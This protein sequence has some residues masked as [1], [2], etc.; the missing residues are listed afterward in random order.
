MCGNSSKFIM[1]IAAI[2]S[3]ETMI[4]QNNMMS[5]MGGLKLY[6]PLSSSIG[7]VKLK[8]PY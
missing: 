7:S 2:I 8:L 5:K 1:D 4:L 3:E 6:L